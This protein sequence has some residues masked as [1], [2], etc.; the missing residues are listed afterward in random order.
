MFEPVYVGEIDSLPVVVLNV[1]NTVLTVTGQMPNDAMPFGIRSE[2]EDIEIEPQG[3][4]I[5]WVWFAPELPSEYESTLMIQ[6]DDPDEDELFVELHGS[7]FNSAKAEDQLHPLKFAITGTYPNP[8]NLSTTIEF[9]IPIL[10]PVTVG[11]YRSTG[12]KIESFTIKSPNS[13]YN[14]ISWDGSEYPSGIYFVR[15][16]T[17][18]KVITAKL[19]SIK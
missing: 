11:I 17:D 8:F 15:L 4:Y 6:S 18:N 10:Q 2:Q 9:T 14:S 3:D 13:G 12:Q 7:G 5:F 1:G 19:L 16:Q